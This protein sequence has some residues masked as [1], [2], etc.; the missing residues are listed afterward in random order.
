MTL[1]STR[2][3]GQGSATAKVA[4][5]GP[6]GQ[7]IAA[8]VAQGT[9]VAVGIACVVWAFG[10]FN[11]G[12]SD[13]TAG[14]G[15]SSAAALSVS[16]ASI[17]RGSIEGKAHL[18]G[19]V[20]SADPYQVMPSVSGKLTTLRVNEG[21]KVKE[22]QVLATLLDLDG[23][24]AGAAATAQANHA[25]ARLELEDLEN[26]TADSLQVAQAK[27]AVKSAQE[28]LDN[29]RR[30]RDKAQTSYDKAKAEADAAKDEVEDEKADAKEEASKSAR[31]QA[32]TPS[33]SAS[34][35]A[36][37]AQA[38]N[39]PAANAA[40]GSA[41]DELAEATADLTKAEG[42]RDSAKVNRDARRDAVTKAEEALHSAERT[43]DTFR[44]IAPAQRTKIEIA[45]AQVDAARTQLA[46]AKR[47]LASLIVRAPADGTVTTLPQKV[48]T[49]VN[50]TSVIAQL[51]TGGF[52]VTAS[53]DSVIA[54]SLQSHP[55][56]TADATI[57]SA[58]IKAKLKVV[59]PTTNA[60]SDQT[61]VTF[62]LLP[63]KT[64]IRP[65]STAGVD[66][67]LPDAKGL[68]V[69]ASA[70]IN[71][72]TDTVVYV[73]KEPE[74][75]G[76]DPNRRET[77]VHRVKVNLGAADSTHAVVFGDGVAAGSQVVTTGQ[78]QLSEGAKVQ[79]LPSQPESSQ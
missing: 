51:D 42:K 5:T 77:T 31:S 2:P 10:F 25:K 44:N 7:R 6:S 55:N 32:A 69:P 38:A 54:A 3:R 14:Q 59:S 61:E 34:A 37:N 30:D 66:I 16:T 26:P 17:E 49:T 22:G 1:P 52:E 43:L 20:E 57:G 40:G 56:L 29:A 8:W 75:A 73:A 41:S 24:L 19:S 33:G 47:N 4:S 39:A 65:G 60:A 58:K 27:A 23:T 12:E 53:A 46:I 71:D 70:I 68:V 21:M 63:G 62:T 48:G 13:K 76:A 45:R 72:G 74:A 78:T 79:I 36:T 50:A 28:V 9:V 35:G 15:D 67:L 64:V 11:G 18:T